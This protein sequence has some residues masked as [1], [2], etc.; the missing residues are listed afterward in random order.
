MESK[1]RPRASP[2]ASSRL[3]LSWK[4]SPSFH[5]VNDNI[6]PKILEKALVS[7]D[8]ARGWRAVSSTRA[9]SVISKPCDSFY[10]VNI[11]RSGT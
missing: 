2:R 4:E 7:P 1:S 6:L 11:I 5:L 3:S 9:G 8:L 10:H